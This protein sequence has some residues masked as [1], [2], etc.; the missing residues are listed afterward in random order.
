[1]EVYRNIFNEVIYI[2]YTLQ[3][4]HY[5]VKLLARCVTQIEM[6]NLKIFELP[7]LNSMVTKEKDHKSYSFTAK[8]KVEGDIKINFL[9]CHYHIFFLL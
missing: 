3:P 8:S 6:T 9:S 2:S 7:N 1:M 5:T 4:N